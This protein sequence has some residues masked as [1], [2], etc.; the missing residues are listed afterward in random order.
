MNLHSVLHSETA[1][2][3]K[4]ISKKHL[5]A[6]LGLSNLSFVPNQ[7]SP[8]K[9]CVSAWVSRTVHARLVKEGKRRGMSLTEFVEHLYNHAVKDV[10]LTPQ[11]YRRIADQTERARR[12]ESAKRVARK[13]G[14]K[15]S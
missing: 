10:E 3:L 9:I 13:I 11:D 4:R 8:D 1:Y 6:T 2:A 7:H 5:T 12:R 15:R 14:K